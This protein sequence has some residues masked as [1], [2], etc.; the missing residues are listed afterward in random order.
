MS[1]YQEI[2]DINL[3]INNNGN[4]NNTK[5]IR[6]GFVLNIFSLISWLTVIAAFFAFF[7]QFISIAYKLFSYSFDGTLI[8]I[9]KFLLQGYGIL[10]SIGI[11]ITELDYEI[12]K[13]IS[14]LQNWILRGF[15][16]CFVALLPFDDDSFPSWTMALTLSGSILLGMGVLYS[17]M[18]CFY[19][20][21]C[22]CMYICICI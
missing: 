10:F 4:N 3:T 2:T 17:I 5:G 6:R 15:L 20:F 11:I 22:V 19:M 9:P 16:Y 8:D 12:S 21:M 1:A 14:I 18:V 7:T 13:S